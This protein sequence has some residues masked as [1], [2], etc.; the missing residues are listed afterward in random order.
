MQR[1]ISDCSKH[2]SS[3]YKSPHCT[4]LPALLN[5][6]YNEK[7]ITVSTAKSAMCDRGGLLHMNILNAAE[8]TPGL[9]TNGF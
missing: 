2:N 1:T 5:E 4:T 3:S 9:E 8:L 7:D 6:T